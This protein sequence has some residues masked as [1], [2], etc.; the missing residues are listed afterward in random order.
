MGVIRR[1][2]DNVAWF[3]N[4]PYFDS[5]YKTKVHI[6]QIIFVILVIALAGARIATKPASIPTSRSDTI[7][8]VMVSRQTWKKRRSNSIRA[9]ELTL[10]GH[11]NH[12][13]PL[14]SAR[15]NTCGK[16]QAMVEYE[17][18]RHLELPRNSVLVRCRYYYVHGDF[19]LLSGGQLRLELDPR[20]GCSLYA[21][22]LPLFRC[23]IL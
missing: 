14:I 13:H 7:G 9:I 18:F 20:A 21:V 19:Q 1:W 6:L 23:W 4:G 15:H 5:R 22:G 17:G 11:Q 3:F 2:R 16:I 10:I 8:I 12:R